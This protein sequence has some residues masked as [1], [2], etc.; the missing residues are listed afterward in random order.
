MP[1]WIGQQVQ[2]VLL[3]EGRKGEKRTAGREPGCRRRARGSACPA[4]ARPRQGRCTG[5]T[6]CRSQGEAASASDIAS[7]GRSLSD[8]RTSCRYGTQA[9]CARTGHELVARRGRLTADRLFYARRRANH[10]PN[11]NKQGFAYVS[12]A[13]PVA[14]WASQAAAHAVRVSLVAPAPSVAERPPS[15]AGACGRRGPQVSAGAATGARDALPMATLAR[16]TDRVLKH[17]FARIATGS[18]SER[19]AAFHHSASVARHC[20]WR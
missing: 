5:S 4:E 18:P 3:G 16:K 1:L 6:E 8:V 2:E 19:A 11:E 17:R 20:C 15:S 7:P 14:F 9:C 13:T 12:G 10:T